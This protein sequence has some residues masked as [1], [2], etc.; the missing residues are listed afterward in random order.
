[1]TIG[2]LIIA[3]MESR[4]SADQLAL[5]R[6]TKAKNAAWSGSVEWSKLY[7]LWKSFVDEYE[8]RAAPKRRAKVDIILPATQS[9][10]KQPKM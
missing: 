1:M 8:P 7:E 2:Q 10:A 6:Q 4:I 9:L 5:F 3:E